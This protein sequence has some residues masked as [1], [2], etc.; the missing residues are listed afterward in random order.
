MSNNM[1][2]S[3]EYISP[4][5]AAYLLGTNQNNRTISRNTVR[6]YANDIIEGNWDECV[7]S[8]LAIDINGI[9]RDGQHRCAAIVEA[10]IG[11]NMWVCHGVS[12][13]GIYDYNRVRSNSDQIS[14]LR[15]DMENVYHTTKF[16]AVAKVLITRAK[17]KQN[18]RRRVSPRE[19]LDFVDEH[20]EELDGFFLKFPQT[21]VPKVS[22]SS[23]LAGLFLA[24]MGGVD[25]NDIINFYNV[26]CSGMSTCSKD[27]PIIAFRNYLKDFDGYPA[28]TDEWVKRCQFALKKYLTGSGCKR[29]QVP[30]DFIWPY[31]WVKED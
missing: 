10:G 7:A 8:P 29:S 19:I 22:T 24:Y 26:L 16:I 21:K 18:F 23:V 30:K 13:R 20:K 5:K 6:T 9:L 3:W 12:E 17:Y 15:P 28:L 4:D 25:F 27:F 2:M 1:T 11:V 14:I 31:P